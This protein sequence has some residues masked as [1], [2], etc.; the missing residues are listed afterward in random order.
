[1]MPTGAPRNL[2]DVLERLPTQPSSPLSPEAY[3]ASRGYL[4]SRL[5]RS[6]GTAPLRFTFTQSL[7][8]TPDW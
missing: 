2:K 3:R 7:E 6:G 1:M 5:N 4:G 8:R